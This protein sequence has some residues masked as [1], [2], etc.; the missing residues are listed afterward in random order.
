MK[1][2]VYL[3]YCIP[4]NKIYIGVHETKNGLDFDGYI[5]NGVRVNVPASYKNPKTP[6]QRAVNKY[7]V[8]QFRRITLASFNTKEEA[9][10]LEGVLVNQDFIRRKDTYNIKLGG[11]GGCPECLKRKV[12]MYDSNGDF[13]K[14]FNT[15]KECMNEID[16]NAH[17]QSH[18]SR[19]IKY[20][21]R[22]RNYQ[23]SYEKVPNMKQYKKLYDGDK[24]SK[25]L[26]NRDMRK[27][28]KYND[29]GDLLEIFENSGEAR[30]R[31]YKNVKLVLNGTRKH[32]NGYTFKY[33]ELD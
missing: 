17:N 29:D 18:I 26:R 4:N 9:Y 28:G 31:G 16:P 27:V 11:S 8:E 7:G 20:G 14:E 12:Y 10:N 30:Q 1:Y 19:A 15:L 3:T 6:F 33:I 23:F 2:I 32:C 5:G 21:T 25:A 24:K 13:V 22:V